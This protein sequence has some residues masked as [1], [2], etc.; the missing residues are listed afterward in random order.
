MLTVLNLYTIDKI[1]KEESAIELK[2]LTKMLYINCLI[3]HFK[4]KKPTVSCSVAFEI[5]ISEVKDYDKYEKLFIELHKSG[6]ITIGLKTIVF[7]NVWGRHIDRS[8]LDKVNPVEYVAGFSF[9]P[10]NHF[11]KEL[12]Q[13][14]GLFDLCGMKYKINESQVKKLIDLFVVEQTTFEKTY[15]NFSDC[16]KHFT[17]W[18]GKNLDKAPKEIVKSNNKILGL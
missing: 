7:N 9:H 10:V 3:Y 12:E 1:F 6:L 4:D 11:K 13:N 17:M 8:R 15:S 5:F 14:R 16:I 2:P 18:A